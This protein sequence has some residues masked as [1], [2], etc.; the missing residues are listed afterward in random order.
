[1]PLLHTYI[2]H[3]PKSEK[4]MQ[5][6]VADLLTKSQLFHTSNKSP[7]IYREVRIKQIHR[8]SDVIVYFSDY[9]IF[10]VECKLNNIQEC[11]KQAVDHAKWADYSYVCMPANAYLANEHRGTL[12]RKKIGLLLWTENNL[13]EAIYAGH[14]SA[15]DYAIRKV[16]IESLKSNNSQENLFKEKIK[17]KQNEQC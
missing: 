2:N 3:F 6:S 11:I 16:V 15:K 13:T 9:R 8:I 17:E 5:E 4:F 12:I 1:M 14:N 10:N 7:K